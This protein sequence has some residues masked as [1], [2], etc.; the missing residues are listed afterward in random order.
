MYNVVIERMK[1]RGMENNSNQER[2]SL[3]TDGVDENLSHEKTL[4]THPALAVLSS[5][6]PKRSTEK[7]ALYDKCA[8]KLIA[9]AKDLRK[10]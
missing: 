7:Q 3:D 5:L 4:S 8:K 10:Y 1:Q 6:I 9:V 2:N